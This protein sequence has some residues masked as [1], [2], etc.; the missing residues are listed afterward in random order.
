VAAARALHY[1]V[2]RGMFVVATLLSALAGSA[3]QQPAPV[4]AGT[5]SIAGRLFDLETNLPLADVIMTLT[6]INGSG[7]LKAITDSEGRY[8]FEGIA[9]GLYRVSAFLEGYARSDAPANSFRPVP[10]SSVVG[11]TAGVARRAVDLALARGATISGRVTHAEGKPVKDGNV[12]AG[13]IDER[14]G[15]S[16]NGVNGVRTSERGEYTLRNLP[17]GIY[18][19]SVRWVD[20]EMLKAKA[21]V[22]DEGPTYFPGT[23]EANEAMSLTLQPGGELRGINI[24]LQSSDLFR[25]AGYV[26]RGAS[27]GRIEANVLLP[28]LALRTV[29]IA[30]DDGAFEVTHLEPGPLT[31]W[32]RAS[33]PDGFE[34]A[35]IEMDLGVDMTGLVLPMEPT[36]QVRGRVV[37][38]DGTPL[39]AGL[40]VAAHL[41]D[42][43]ATQ[44]DP[45]PRDR[46]DVTEDGAFHLRNLFG[47]RTLTVVGLTHEHMLDHVLQGRTVLKMLSLK[48][49]A[50]IDD[51]TLVVRR[52]D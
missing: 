24:R 39:P 25:F 16:L 30:D 23:R 46:V 7:V 13:L 49:G 52:R 1:V 11:V 9:A 14:G 19:V 2:M 5:A 42:R 47:N 27:E 32:A 15:I 28:G 45:L 21:R 44:I 43:N 51:V 48:S 35:W 41:V 6:M 20:P 17:A 33:T 29:E 8:V 22:D 4:P 38:N 3:A 34:A 50:S 31:F 36:A 37:M 10:G 26:L 12:I 40:Q 18:W